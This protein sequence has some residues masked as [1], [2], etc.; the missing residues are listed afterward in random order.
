MNIIKLI[1]I[2][3]ISIFLLHLTVSVATGNANLSK[4]NI[5]YARSIFKQIEKGNWQNAIRKSKKINNKMLEQ[6]VY[7]LYLNKK[8]N[9][10]NFN[11]YQ[12]FIKQNPNLPKINRL[13]HFAEYK[14]NIKSISPQLVIN[15]FKIKEPLTSYGKIKLG[16]ALIA[17]G[18]AL[19]GEKLIKTNW[20]NAN[21]TNNDLSYLLKNYKNIIKEK[22][23]IDRAEWLA[24]ENKSQQL[25]NLFKYLPRDYKSLYKARYLLM[26]RL[27]GVDF[28]IKNVPN[29]YKNNQGLLYHRLRWKI[30]TEK[31]DSA[32]NLL[33]KA[34]SNVENFNRP[35][36]FWNPTSTIVRHLVYRKKYLSA[37]K[38]ASQHYLKQGSK[39]AEAEWLSGWIAL[40]FLNEPSRAL[41]HFLNMAKRV[42]NPRSRSRAA[43][44]CARSYELLN[45]PTQA[46]KWY[47]KGSAYLTTYHGQLSFH[48]IFPNKKTSLSDPPI[49]SK[50]TENNFNDNQ[51]VQAVKILKAINRTHYS[52]DILEHLATM[53]GKTEN[54]FLTAQLAMNI[55]RKDYAIKIAK[56]ASYQKRYYINFN[57]PTLKVPSLVAKKK[58][59]PA[60]LILAVIRQES[61]FNVSAESNKG[62]MGLMQIMPD[63]AREV[64]RKTRVWYNPGKLK[65]DQKYNINL[66]SYYLQMMLDKYR[67][68]YPLAL[69]A[70]NAGQKRV[71]RWL[72][73][74]GDPRKKEIHYAEWIELIP[75]KETRNYVQRVLENV[76]V[77]RYAT[78]DEPIKLYNFF[79]N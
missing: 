25:A 59:P 5:E 76:N 77:Y 6:L 19:E 44:W 27:Y 62:A 3:I 17:V 31:I 9:N 7:W 60:E 41:D 50:I 74:N 1:K 45:Q 63:T 52:R 14:I 66:G 8:T 67:G 32:I 47:I 22:D 43:Y 46:K 79:E 71:D 24:W 78:S 61:E 54:E 26:I 49:I 64:A 29:K 11:D 68:S 48:K 51:W 72:K 35:D 4:K 58:M 15:Y 36:K 42:H 20:K 75:F 18:N 55:G 28:A 39:Y 40:K 53:D 73:I 30:K 12:N 21:L 23:I 37:Y 69:A 2:A 33:L 70:Y 57:Y 13:K 65:R 38:I 10:A 16:E 56:K 34:K